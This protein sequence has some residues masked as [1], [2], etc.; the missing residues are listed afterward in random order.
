MATRD[1]RNY[2]QFEAFRTRAAADL[3]ARVPLRRAGEVIDLGC[4]PGNS[5]ELLLAR[6]PHAKVTGVDS[7]PEKLDRAS[8][9]VPG[10]TYVQ[11][12]L[13]EYQ[14]DGAAD[15][16]FANACLHWLDNHEKL[17]P[18]LFAGVAPGGV[19]AFQVS[20]TPDE[21]SHRLLGEVA[22]TLGAGDVAG[23]RRVPQPEEYYDL[24]CAAAT[25]DIWRTDYFHDMSD[26]NAIVR[27]VCGTGL[28]PYLA[29]L[30]VA[31]RPLFLERYTAA[32]ARAYP[33][34]PNGHRLLKV[35]RLFVVA[36]KSPR[37]G[38][39]LVG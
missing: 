13:A 2:L 6:W 5:T 31:D 33:P 29:A 4:G 28:R 30:E 37:A 15:V 16:V 39:R 1:D 38:M 24:L 32:L 9:N 34:Q 14:W 25:V 7:S 27:W 26:E 21:A 11:A 19:L 17:I 22:A 35:P 3:L 18:R 10:P 20:L 36:K 8:K 23:V 12:D